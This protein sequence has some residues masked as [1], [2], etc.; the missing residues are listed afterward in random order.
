MSPP[1]D[2]GYCSDGI[3]A[4]AERD[5]ALLQELF[6]W[7]GIV[8]APNSLKN[9]TVSLGSNNAAL[10]GGTGPMEIRIHQSPRSHLTASFDQR[11]VEF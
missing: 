6:Q 9:E 11:E 1:N 4:A 10:Q 7:I 3:H 5:R 2:S 8:S